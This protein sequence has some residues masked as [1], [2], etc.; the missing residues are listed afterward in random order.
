MMNVHVPTRTLSFRMMRSLW[1]AAAVSL[2]YAHVSA[3]EVSISWL[4]ELDNTIASVRS[5]GVSSYLS[6]KVKDVARE[7]VPTAFGNRADAVRGASKAGEHVF[8]IQSRG[9]DAIRR[10]DESGSSDSADDFY[11]WLR[12]D[13]LPDLMRDAAPEK[14]RQAID[15]ARTLGDNAAFLAGKADAALQAGRSLATRVGSYFVGGNA[16][17]LEPAGSDTRYVVE[18]TGSRPWRVSVDDERLAIA[19]GGI[20]FRP[21]AFSAADIST[22]ERDLNLNRGSAARDSSGDVDALAQSLGVNSTTL[23]GA[24]I[25]A[26]EAAAALREWDAE[27]TRKA[28][29][30][31]RLAEQRRAEAEERRRVEAE[32]QRTEALRR[33]QAEEA[34]RLAREEDERR[35]S[36]SARVR[37]EPR[38]PSFG[39]MLIGDIGRAVLRNKYGVAP[40]P[41]PGVRGESANDGCSGA[42]S[43]IEQCSQ[44]VQSARGI[45][46]S[47]QAAARCMS[48]IESRYSSC[49]DVVAGAADMRRQALNQG[50]SI[51]STCNSA[52]DCARLWGVAA[53]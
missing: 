29:E 8:A 49:P 19:T 9:V 1:T 27:Q 2:A 38:S 34:E 48:S 44:R 23:R 7:L 46:D 10:M 28:E 45:C 41:T 17:G 32:Y 12:G 50:A 35:I 16:Y 47:S 25:D 21:S 36:R 40:L 30:A 43:A 14:V 37:P 33:R 22:L 6:E 24:A 20:S 52:R 53:N 18:T 51:C 15:G 5:Q 31:R 42:H 11:R 3:V 26:D 13:K 39:E 4:R